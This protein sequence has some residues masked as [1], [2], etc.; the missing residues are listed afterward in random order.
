[1]IEIGSG[2]DGYWVC[3]ER[4]LGLGY[5]RR[6]GLMDQ[7]GGTFMIEIGSGLDGC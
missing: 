3:Q 4:L 1:M 7:G 2:L 6:A 5:V